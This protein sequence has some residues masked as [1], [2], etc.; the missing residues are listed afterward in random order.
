MI[1]IFRSPGARRL[2]VPCVMFACMAGAGVAPV[3][4]ETPPPVEVTSVPPPQTATVDLRVSGDEIRLT[5]EETV[6]LALER[7]PALRANRYLRQQ[8]RLGIEAAM[9]QYD[10]ALFGAVS[11]SE[12]ESPAASNL[13]G[14]A[15]QKQERQG[16]D[17][18]VSQL[19]SSGGVGSVDWGN[20]R[21]DSNSEFSLLNPSFASG[22]DFTFEQPLLRGFGRAATDY[23]VEVARNG[24]RIA[25][26]VFVQQV[27]ATIQ[28]AAVAYWNLVEARFQLTVAEESRGLARELH[29]NN[30]TR[31]EVGT[32]APLELVASEAGIATREEEIIRARAA[33][34]DAEDRL[35]ALLALPVGETWTRQ[36]VPDTEVRVAPLEVDLQAAL[37]RALGS[38]AELSAQRSSIHGLELDAAFRR[39]ELKP[40]LDLRATY[41]WNG[42]GG[43]AIV[44][45]AEGNVV[46]VI[47]GGWSDA[48]EQITDMDFPGWSIALQFSYPLQNRTARARSAIAE[49]GL[50]Q[51]RALLTDLELLV[52]T[53]VRAAVRGL[54][55]ARQ[56]IQSAEVSVRLA[57]RNLDAERKKYE[58]G[59]STSFQ[60]LEVQ[61]DA[62]AARS[63]L[64]AALASYRRALV[65]YHR[66]IGDL[67]EASQVRIAG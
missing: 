64:V 41:G 40:R 58:N 22:L 29:Q 25:Q 35:R 49:V 8:S 24:D 56:Q 44:R 65:E 14:A 53:E 54:E 4:G 45:D 17:L 52:A 1:E 48:L 2:A 27:V 42:V 7:N 32:L 23:A 20:G 34:G 3:A 28:R 11:A 47:D 37:A 63:R 15:V 31:V 43:D 6:R 61:E 59:L 67:P 46:T 19:F 55:T 62:T 60:I 38:R 13:D 33:I 26:D 16:L 12:D 36:I 50:E 51:G 5:L 30:Q 9:G 57:E 21:F 66:A 10:L 18:G 39:Q